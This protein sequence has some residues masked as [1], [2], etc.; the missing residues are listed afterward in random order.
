[1]KLKGK[2]EI[3]KGRTVN[4]E[5]FLYEEDNIVVDGAGE[6]IVNML[7][8]TPSLSAI[9]DSRYILDTSN[10]TIQAMSFGKDEA[11]YKKHAHI[12]TWSAIDYYQSQGLTKN[13]S[14]LSGAAIVFTS[15]NSNPP[16]GIWSYFP[17]AV[18]GNPLYKDYNILPSFPS[19][20]D[21]KL[22]KSS[23]TPWAYTTSGWFPTNFSNE[24]SNTVSAAFVKLGKLGHNP[25]VVHK[26]VS[27]IVGIGEYGILGGAYPEATK[28]G[29]S[30]GAIFSDLSQV[31]PSHF[32]PAYEILSST[33]NSTFNE[34]SSMDTSGY[35]GKVYSLAG[36]VA[37]S[38]A[39]VGSTMTPI[40]NVPKIHLSGLIVS[41]NTD[42]SSTGEVI[43]QT[44]ISSG[45]LGFSNF[46]GGI[47]NIGLWALDI[48]ESLKTGVQPPYI[49]HP[50]Q[51]YRKY[52]LFSKK[53]FTTN[54]AE[55]HDFGTSS[56]GL[57]H[58]KDLTL[59][60][61]LYF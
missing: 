15:S 47:Y 52:K 6:I 30:P 58:Y 16:K 51:H 8:T 2:V 28:Y 36:N 19:P 40:K 44:Y 60:W 34:A 38:N 57:Q 4:K 45:D 56:P 18:K 37:P 27:S 42:F 22:E 10:Y 9:P 26:E 55:I 54:L 17:S 41:S 20:L 5:N 43:Y 3:Y 59:I 61:R 23:N 21:T 29:G 12:D 48:R 49:W 53:S 14:Y 32:S 46:Y 31:M 11:G 24:I 50:T 33:F 39:L 35:L 13:Q 25:N 7:T 1:M